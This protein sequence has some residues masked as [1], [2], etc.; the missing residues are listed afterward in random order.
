MQVLDDE[1]R[2]PLSEASSRT[3]RVRFE[4]LDW[5]EQGEQSAD[6]WLRLGIRAGP[7]VTLHSRTLKS[8]GALEIVTSSNAVGGRRTT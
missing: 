6:A 3:A 8:P 4:A 2:L 7:I 5:L 1:I